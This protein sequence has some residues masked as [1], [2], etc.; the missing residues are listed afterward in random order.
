MK[1]ILGTEKGKHFSCPPGI[2]PVS[3]KVKK[4]CFDILRDVIN[5]ASVL[6][7]FAGSGSLGIE[8]ISAG[9]RKALFIDNNQACVRVIQQNISAL[10]LTAKAEVYANDALRAVQ[11]LQGRGERFDVIF[12]DPPYYTDLLT[13]TLQILNEYDILAPSSYLVLFSYIKDVINDSGIQFSRVLER[14]YG[15]TRFLIYE[16]T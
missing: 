3:L 15:Q 2:R 5:D 4:A 1:I 16:K 10:N 12:L 9:A 8:A 13:R 14:I 6:D 11:Y 7:L